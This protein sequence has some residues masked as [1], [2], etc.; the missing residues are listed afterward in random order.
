MADA[1]FTHTQQRVLG[2]L[3]GQPQRSFVVT[4]LIALT[5]AGSGGVQRELARLV[6]SGLLTQRKLG[7]QKHYQANPAAPIHDELVGIVQKTTGLAEP[8]RAA[9]A[10]LADGIVAAF[11]YGSVAKRRDTAASDIDLMIVSETLT[12]AE[13]FGAVE[14]ASAQLGRA[15]NPTVYTCAELRR[16]KEDGN[17]F[18]TRVLEQPKLW[19]IGS[20]LDLTT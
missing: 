2:L 11:I 8:L 17:A 7:N 20:E 19:L 1:L 15:V 16:R 12:Y 3:F 5:G 14:A 9:L 10:P 6:A 13:V 4:E 18:V